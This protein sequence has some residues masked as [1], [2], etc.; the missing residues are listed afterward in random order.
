M[1]LC[2]KSSSLGFDIAL[3]ISARLFFHHQKLDQAKDS[4]IVPLRFEYG[5]V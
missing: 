5:N 1:F 4:P 3:I 2:I